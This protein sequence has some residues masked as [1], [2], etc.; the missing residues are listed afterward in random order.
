M[1]IRF[2]KLQS[3]KFLLISLVFTGLAF[4]IAESFGKETADF[5]GN[6]IFVLAVIPVILSGIL[7]KRNDWTGDHGKAWIFFI[8]SAVLWFVA[9]QV[10]TVVE[11]VYK[12]KPFSIWRRFFLF[13]W[14]SVLFCICHP[15]S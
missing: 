14:L 7:V 10:W 3:K 1:Q 5:F 4:L 9:E 11:T 2:E 12:E 13:S 6:W 15:L 8:V